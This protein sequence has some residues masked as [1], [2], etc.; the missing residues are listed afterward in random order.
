MDPPDARRRVRRAHHGH[1]GGVR[2]VD[3]VRI[4]TAPAH[5]AQILDARHGR[6]D[7]EAGRAVRLVTVV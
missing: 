3:V 5:E 4:A 6:A 7:A 1:V 2:N